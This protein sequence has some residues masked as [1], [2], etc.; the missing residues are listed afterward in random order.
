MAVIMNTNLID[1]TLNTFPFFL[2]Y[3]SLHTF[4]LC[5]FSKVFICADSRESSIYLFQNRN[6]FK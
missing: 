3:L 5:N 2:V 6:F 4:T 1:A